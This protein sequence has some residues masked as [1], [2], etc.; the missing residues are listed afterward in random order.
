MPQQREDE[1]QIF[2]FP[3]LGN[4]WTRSLVAGRAS[5]PA[6]TCT[7][8]DEHGK[9]SGVISFPVEGLD[10]LR[11]PPAVGA[12][13]TRSLRGPMK[14]VRLR[15]YT[16][17]KGLGCYE[18]AVIIGITRIPVPTAALMIREAIGR[19]LRATLEIPCRESSLMGL[20]PVSLAEEGKVP[21]RDRLIA[22]TLAERMRKLTALGGRYATAADK[23]HKH[24][25]H[26][27]RQSELCKWHF[28]ASKV[29]SII[30]EKV[31][32]IYI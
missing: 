5:N 25:A 4:A 28:G 32:M 2:K 20:D 29:I 16:G 15:E 12:T 6:R 21:Y 23:L 11:M 17:H 27:D 8:E 31:G 22:E 18:R 14:I 7:P 19:I 30:D 9:E 10:S 3:G 13:D 24:A 1:G 26:L